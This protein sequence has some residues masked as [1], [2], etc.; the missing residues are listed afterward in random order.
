MP[1]FKE[2]YEYAYSKSKRVPKD[3]DSDKKSI[4]HEHAEKLAINGCYDELKFMLQHGYPMSY[5]CEKNCF[6]TLNRRMISLV[7][8][9]VSAVGW[10]LHN[11]NSK[12]VQLVKMGFYPS[13][14]SISN[15]YRCED[16]E[17]KAKNFDVIGYA[18]PKDHLDALKYAIGNYHPELA[19]EFI[20]R[21]GNRFETNSPD[22]WD[23]KY[24]TT[25]SAYTKMCEILGISEEDHAHE[26]FKEAMHSMIYAIGKEKR[27][28]YRSLVLKLFKFSPD[29]DDDEY[30][31][32]AIE[33]DDLKLAAELLKCGASPDG[34][35]KWKKKASYEM[36]KLIMER[37]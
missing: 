27:N 9:Q 3:Y 17:Q 25:Y 33:R 16:I 11:E 14:K 18:N 28:M 21:F 8:D 32:F 2:L 29:C 37:L 1:Q 13:V 20:S 12:G 24:F 6:R 30:M 19:R 5:D 15:F 23:L 36:Y 4:L 22:S 7:E 26:L 31:E 35:R 34:V 10:L